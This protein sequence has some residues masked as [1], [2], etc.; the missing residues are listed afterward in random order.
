MTREE[1]EAFEAMPA[2]AAIL[3]MRDWDDKAKVS[4]PVHRGHQITI[5]CE[6]NRVRILKIGN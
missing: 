6:T 3:A 1:A 2:F 4:F 5:T